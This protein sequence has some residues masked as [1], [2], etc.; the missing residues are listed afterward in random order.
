MTKVSAKVLLLNDEDNVLIVCAPIQKSE[1][2]EI[3]GDAVPAPADLDLGHKLA[4]RDISKGSVIS[5]YG[6]PIGEASADIRKGDHVHVHNVIS[7]YTAIEM[8]E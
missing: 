2:I 3:E 4:R 7:R 1:P 5:K 6:M 8:M